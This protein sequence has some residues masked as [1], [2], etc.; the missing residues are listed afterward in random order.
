M[1]ESHE[2]HALEFGGS[3]VGTE[4]YGSLGFQQIDRVPVYTVSQDFSAET[5]RQ[6]R[7]GLVAT[8][9][10]ERPFYHRYQWVV[11]DLRM[12]DGWEPG[13][14]E[15]VAQLRDRLRELGGDLV[16]VAYDT[17]ALAGDYLTAET[18]QEAVDLVK[19]RRAA[20]REAALRR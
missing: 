10:P 17:S 20:A 15:F 13:A 19:Q 2:R 18:V 8:W 5:A 11:L 6:I 12:V 9:G 4:F 7:Y 16:L 3:P 1:A 14:P